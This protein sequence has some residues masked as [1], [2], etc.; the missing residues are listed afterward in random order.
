[1]HTC[2]ILYSAEIA[3]L[4]EGWGGWAGWEG[5]GV[6]VLNYWALAAVYCTCSRLL[7][8]VIHCLNLPLLLHA[9]RVLKPASQTSVSMTLDI[10]HQNPKTIM[11]FFADFQGPLDW[12]WL[13]TL[14]HFE[15]HRDGPS[16]V[17]STLMCHLS[18]N[19]E[20]I[21]GSYLLSQVSI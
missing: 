18:Y 7:L 15:H 1:M 6:S 21:M 12:F 5:M 20:K 19:S 13:R 10:W 16:V 8:N 14:V 4:L 17:P 2:G 3:D 9:S 11:F